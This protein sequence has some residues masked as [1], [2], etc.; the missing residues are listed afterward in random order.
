LDNKISKFGRDFVAPFRGNPIET[1][2]KDVPIALILVTVVT[3]I[4]TGRSKTM[5]HLPA[6]PKFQP[7]TK[8]GSLGSTEPS[9]D[10]FIAA[11]NNSALLLIVA[12]CGLGLLITLNFILRFPDFGAAIEQFTQF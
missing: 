2:S 8:P 9:W 3:T 12:F 5:T 6:S 1:Q 4:S 10:R 11:I 7:L